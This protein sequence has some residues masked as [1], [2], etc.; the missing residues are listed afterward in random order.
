VVIRG[1][2]GATLFAS[3]VFTGPALRTQAAPALAPGRYAF[4]CAIHPDMNGNLTSR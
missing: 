3:E 2:D 4:I 1:A